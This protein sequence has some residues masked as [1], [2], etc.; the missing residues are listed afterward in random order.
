MIP[1]STGISSVLQAEPVLMKRTNQVTCRIY[2]TIC[3]YAAGMWAFLTTGK[4]LVIVFGKADR[5]A[6][7]GNFG[8]AAGVETDFINTFCY[9]M[10]LIFHG[11]FV[12][13]RF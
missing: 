3:K 8:K 11:S 12:C 9:F 5:F 2:I 6:I 1:F 13:H 7:D 10:P 4:N